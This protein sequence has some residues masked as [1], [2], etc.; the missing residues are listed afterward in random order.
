MLKKII[1]LVGLLF[2]F[3]ACND[4]EDL[5]FK[6]FQGIQFDKFENNE[7]FFTAN[8]EVE[9]PN[10]FNLT[11]KPSDVDIFAD[12]NYLGKAFLLKKV[13]LKKRSSGVYAAPL[14]LKLEGGQLLKLLTL[15]KKPSV[16]LKISGK[17][18]G[19]VGIFSKKFDIEKTKTISG[20]DLKLDGLFGKGS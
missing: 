13:K 16:E 19:A 11:L 2:V 4:F 18:K 5:N 1:Y 20:A 17:L 14:K 15:V 10:R 9:N 7:V 8:F 3:S 12:G 6:N